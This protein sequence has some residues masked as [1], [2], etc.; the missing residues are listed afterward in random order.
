VIEHEASEI[1]SSSSATTGKDLMT[2]KLEAKT[3]ET[4]PADYS[5]VDAIFVN[6]SAFVGTNPTDESITSGLLV[7]R[8]QR[9]SVELVRTLNE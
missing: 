3:A 5:R 2:K 7:T 4:I 8:E 6:T 1:E 9:G